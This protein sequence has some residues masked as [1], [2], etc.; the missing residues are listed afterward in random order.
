MVFLGAVHLIPFS[1]HLAV[2]PLLVLVVVPVV[3]PVVAVADVELL[4]PVE[5]AA[6]QLR[7]ANE[8]VPLHYRRRLA[9]RRRI[10]TFG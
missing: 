10:S 2:V 6:F 3:V 1:D 7:R 8:T 9:Y 5:A 4:R